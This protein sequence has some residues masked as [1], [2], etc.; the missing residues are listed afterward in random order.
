MANKI[1]LAEAQ[2]QGYAFGKHGAWLYELIS[3]M[4]LTKKEWE[5][6]NKKYPMS[7]LNESEKTE[8]DEYF[9]RKKTKKIKSCR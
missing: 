5:L 3:G 4:G 9:E 8:I 6:L 1:D 2:L 7:Y